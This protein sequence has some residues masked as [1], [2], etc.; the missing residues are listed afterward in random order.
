MRRRRDLRRLLLLLSRR[1][2]CRRPHV[3]IDEHE[4]SCVYKE[5]HPTT[6]GNNG[7]RKGVVDGDGSVIR[8]MNKSPSIVAASKRAFGRFQKTHDDFD[9]SFVP[10]PTTALSSTHREPHRV[11]TQKPTTTI[12]QHEDGI[13][14]E[15]ALHERL[16]DHAERTQRRLFGTHRDTHD[17]YEHRHTSP[18]GDNVAIC[19]IR[20]PS[21][22]TID[23][24]PF[25]DR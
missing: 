11:T 5:Y 23:I 14:P 22:R 12:V 7:L 1:R 9:L 15:V 24:W 2:R 20:M 21:C 6:T 3:C 4:T 19:R 25:S 17:T 18:T 13:R 10:S 16:A 8:L